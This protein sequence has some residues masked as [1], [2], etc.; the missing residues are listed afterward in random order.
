MATENGRM[1]HSSI[2]GYNKDDVN[3]YILEMDRKNKEKTDKLS[4]DLDKM[5]KLNAEL[6]EKNEKADADIAEATARL[7]ILQAELDQLKEENK[8]L[9][10]NLQDLTKRHDFYKL[11]TEAQNEALA[12]A[13]DENALL[14]EK[15]KDA[16]EK[17]AA[18]VET[19]RSAYEGEIKEIKNTAKIDDGIAYKLDMYDKISS[20]IGDILI[21]ANRNS[22]EIITSAKNEAAKILTQTNDN[23][24]ANAR[25][26]KDGIVTCAAET[27]GEIKNDFNSNMSGCVKEMQTCLKEIEYETNALVALLNKKHEE[28]TARIDFY[29]SNISDSVNGRLDSMNTRCGD[30]IRTERAE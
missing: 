4:E 20:Q 22:D 7:A 18:D 25:R 26:M 11:Q 8:S 3:R 30:I 16:A 2:S 12:K 19:L 21:N 9:S 17:Y 15:I 5:N 28:M 23:A 1:F 14:N 10:E 13:K 29:H 27:L 24:T 6:T